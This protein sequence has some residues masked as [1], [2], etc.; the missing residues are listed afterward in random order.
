MADTTFPVPISL[1]FPGNLE[2]IPAVRKFVAEAVLSCGFQPKFV[3]RCEVIVDE[4]CNNAVTYGSVS[5]SATIKLFCQIF[6]DRVELAISDEGGK[7]E[8]VVKLKQAI[9]ANETTQN[10]SEINKQNMGMEIVRL[11]A[12]K[13][14]LQ[15]DESRGVTTVRVVKKCEKVQ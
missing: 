5:V 6:A 10:V 1:A 12:E 2:Y 9:K 3:Y 15:I 7:K 13:V 11:L 14:D 8:N 4:L